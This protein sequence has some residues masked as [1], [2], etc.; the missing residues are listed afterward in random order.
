MNLNMVL[1]NTLYICI[2]VCMST[3]LGRCKRNLYTRLYICIEKHVDLYRSLHICKIRCVIICKRFCTR[4]RVE[5]V[6]LYGSL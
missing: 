1:L 3:R 2:G 4:A 5:S 6:Y